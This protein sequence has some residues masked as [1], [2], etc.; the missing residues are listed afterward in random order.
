M[1]NAA[2]RGPDEDAAAATYDAIV[3]GAG[4]AGLYAIYRLRQLGFKARGFERADGVGGTWYWNRYPGARCDVDS[5]DYSYSFSGE[6]EQEWEWTERYPTQP[7][8]LRYIN[9]VADRFDL[10]RDIEFATVVTSATYDEARNHWTVTTDRGARVS[11]PFLI[12]AVGC[13]S[14][15]N[16]PDFKGIEN[17]SRDWYHTGRWPHGG[18]DFS[19]K[20]VGIIGT[21]STGI[22]VIPQVASQADH[23]YVFQRT[24]NFSVPAVNHPLAPEFQH[25]LKAR[26]PA[27]RQEARESGFGQPV[28]PNMKSA[29]EVTPEEQKAELDQRWQRGGGAALLL[30]FVDLLSRQ[31]S[32][33]VAA[34]YVRGRIRETVTDPRTAEMLCP[35][36]H[37]IGTKRICVDIDYYKTYNRD[38]VTLIDVRSAPIDE[39]TATGVRLADGREVEVDALVFATGFDAVTGTLFNMNIRGREA[40]PLQMKWADGPRTYLGLSTAGFPNLFMITGPNSP[41]VLSNMVVSIEQHVEWITDLLVQLRDQGVE[42]IEPSLEAE[43]AWTDHCVEVANATLF[44]RAN[45]WYMGRN[46]PGKPAVLLPY[47]GGVGAYRQQCDKVKD[48]DYEGFVLDGS[49]VPLISSDPEEEFVDE[50]TAIVTDTSY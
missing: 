9:H 38:N 25:G 47:V 2:R 31:E 19:G 21:G 48:N 41:S 32:N 34:E 20:R 29:L 35:Y 18:V 45:S 6:L 44:P 5:M 49:P 30:A 11:A 40:I 36:D 17:F 15:P 3:V 39:L 50:P 14:A 12:T 22:Q 4:I 13:L 33:E 43:E 42:V 28:E 10:R 16:R 46:I 23:L 8:L 26:Y 1:E 37:P 24:P 27:Y 7:E